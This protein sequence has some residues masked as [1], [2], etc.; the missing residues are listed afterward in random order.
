M[1]MGESLL[2]YG[3]VLDPEEVERRILAVTPEDVQR[4]ACYCLNRARLGV[5]VVGPIKDQEKIKGWL[6]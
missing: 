5:A 3:K 2:G 4:V 1:W 6:S